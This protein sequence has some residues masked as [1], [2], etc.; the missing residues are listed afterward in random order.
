MDQA[1]R[2]FHLST[3][4]TN[5]RQGMVQIMTMDTEV[6]ETKKKVEMELNEQVVGRMAIGVMFNIPTNRKGVSF[7]SAPLDL[8]WK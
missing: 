5:Q 4:Q 1:G 7:S 3:E 2:N 6:Q 8:P